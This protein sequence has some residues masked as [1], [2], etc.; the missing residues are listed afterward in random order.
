MDSQQ[1]YD[2]LSNME[3]NQIV[4]ELASKFKEESNNETMIM[5][6]YLVS[7]DL[8]FIEKSRNGDDLRDLVIESARKNGQYAGMYWED[9]MD[10]HEGSEEFV[11]YDDG[12]PWVAFLD[13]WKALTQ[14]AKAGK[15]YHT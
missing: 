5:L 9:A 6:N 8:D 3:V 15:P 4:F 12:L 1:M 14:V 13:A 7:F 2:I 10:S 11:M